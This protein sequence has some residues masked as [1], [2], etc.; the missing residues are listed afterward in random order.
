MPGANASTM[1]AGIW[2]LAFSALLRARTS[3]TI[4]ARSILAKR[5]PGQRAPKGQAWPMPLPFPEVHCRARSREKDGASLKLGINY[6][7]LML[8]WLHSGERLCDT[9]SF[10]LG[11]RLNLAQWQVVRRIS[12][13]VASWNSQGA[14]SSADMGRSAAKVESVEGELSRLEEAACSLRFAEEAYF[15]RRDEQSHFG[16]A[17]APGEEAGVLAG[18]GIDHVAKDIEPERL[19][20]HGV[21][22]FDP[23]PFLDYN[24]R[25]TYR[26][27]LDFA[28][29]IDPDDPRLPRVKLRCPASRRVQVVEKLDSVS[30]LALLD[31]AKCR[32]GL[33]NGLFSIPKDQVRDR[34]VLDARRANAAEQSERRWIFSLGS[35]QQFLHI[36]MEPDE[37]MEINA[38]DLREFY[39]C[40]QVG[41]QRRERNILQGVYKPADLRHLN[42]YYPELDGAKEVVAALDTMAMGDT[43]AVAYG[44]VAHLALLL[45]TGHFSLTDFITLKNRPSRKKWHVGLMI[46]DFILLEVC[47]EGRRSELVRRMVEDVR[48][49]YARYGL[50][51]HEGKAV[52]AESA[53]LAEGARSA[54]DRS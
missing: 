47:K 8:N 15:R 27:P 16:F 50:P 31:G 29:A 45:R 53:L 2:E 19:F 51:R 5:A 13:L 18:G 49:A 36:F 28:E 12:P 6:V 40:F 39:H 38:E 14:V 22:S 41:P 52:E 42:A 1:H 4:F 10:T 21:P 35:L 30:R 43:N 23:E 26:R 37:H 25:M 7:V 24:N 9:S 34:M 46:D 44:Q 17:G 20:F 11:T 54:Q 33:E 48:E 32:R 3:L